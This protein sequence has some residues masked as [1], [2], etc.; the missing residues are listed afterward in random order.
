MTQKASLLAV[1]T[2]FIGLWTLTSYIYCQGGGLV[3]ETKL[4]MQKL[5]LKM[6]GGFS[7]RGSVIARF[8]STCTCS[9]WLTYCQLFSLWL[10][11]L[12]T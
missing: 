10:V 6:Q 11:Q 8:Y 5:E 4:P 12:T 3:R 1:A 9:F 2:A 7:A